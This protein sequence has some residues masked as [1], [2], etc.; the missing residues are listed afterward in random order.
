MQ[1]IRAFSPYIG[2]KPT[3]YEHFTRKPSAHHDVLQPPGQYTRSLQVQ[4]LWNLSGDVQSCWSRVKT[5]HQ[6][7][8]QTHQDNGE[9]AEIQAG[10]STVSPGGL[11]A[12]WCKDVS[13]STLSKTV[14]QR[15]G[16]RS[17]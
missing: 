5:P 8:W 15:H 13:T 4:F 17:M 6:N 9:Q 3:Y 12:D 14:W 1:E 2:Y 7:G 16:Q 11:E 10:E